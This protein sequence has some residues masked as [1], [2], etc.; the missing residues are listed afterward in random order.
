MT[1]ARIITLIIVIGIIAGC[2]TTMQEPPTPL[3][4]IQAEPSPAVTYTPLP[5][6]FTPTVTGAPPTPTN[7]PKPTRTAVAATP[8]P[9]ITLPV[10]YTIDGLRMASFYPDGTRVAGLIVEGDPNVKKSLDLFLVD[11]QSKVRVRIASPTNKESPP[12]ADAIP[13]II[14]PRL[15]GDWVVWIDLLSGSYPLGDWVLYAKNMRTNELRVLDRGNYPRLKQAPPFNPP[16]NPSI[17]MYGNTVISTE[18]GGT[19]EKP[20]MIMRLYD[21]ANQNTRV[22]L[23][24]PDIATYR[25]E[26]SGFYEDMI[27]YRRIRYRQSENNQGYRTTGQI[28]ALNLKTLQQT[29]ITPEQETVDY[30]GGA[31]WGRNVLYASYEENTAASKEAHTSVQLYDII[32]GKAT[33]LATGTT[34]FNLLS[35]GERYALWSDSSQDKPTPLQAYDLT[36]KK[37]VTLAPDS[38]AGE[39]ITRDRTILWQSADGLNGYQY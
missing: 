20:L 24:E 33:E 5:V 10:T 3:V 39:R 2:S 30:Y 15:S 6:L 29:A 23:E 16:L 11:L 4:V 19:A 14:S 7:T 25:I 18:Y 35:I 12:V 31:I 28:F 9:T 27:I 17:A 36:Q 22:L 21:L 38:L 34:A 32:S 8:T 37:P 26:I 1:V 13:Q